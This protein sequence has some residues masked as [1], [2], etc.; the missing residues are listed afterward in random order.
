[1]EDD[2]RG[3]RTK[4]EDAVMHLVLRVFGK[5]LLSLSTEAAPQDDDRYEDST[6]TFL[7]F[8]PPRTDFGPGKDWEL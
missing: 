7:G 5:E 1:M 6:G 3:P 2:V 8:S 4:R